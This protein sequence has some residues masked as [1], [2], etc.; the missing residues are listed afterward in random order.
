MTWFWPA[1]PS[2]W[3]QG[4]SSRAW[5][6]VCSPI[7]TS[8][9]RSSRY[10]SSGRDPRRI[11]EQ[12]W[13]LDDEGEIPVPAPVSE[14][15]PC[16]PPVFS[17]GWSQ[18]PRWS[19]RAARS[20]ADAAFEELVLD[21]QPTVTKPS[22]IIDDIMRYSQNPRSSGN[23]YSPETRDWAF[24]LLQTCGVKALDIVRRHLPLP[25]RQSLEARSPIRK[26]LV[27]LT[28]FDQVGPR[29]KE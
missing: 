21:E 3:Q 29:V 15:P 2:Q 11:Y 23:R 6:P 26:H 9:R 20:P 14:S 16:H 7:A 8:A 13:D 18:Q 24:E 22:P 1:N 25:S 19:T 17:S 28:D 12:R 27:D 4:R 10:T 5:P